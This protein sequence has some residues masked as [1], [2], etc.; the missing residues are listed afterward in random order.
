MPTV[1][2]VALSLFGLFLVQLLLGIRRVARN[3]GS[4]CLGS[5]SDVLEQ[6]KVTLQQPLGSIF[7]FWHRLCSGILD[8]TYSW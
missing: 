6:P 1:L 7:P 3:V 8:F 2:P 4:V 5:Q